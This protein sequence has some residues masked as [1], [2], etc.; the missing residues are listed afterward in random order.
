MIWYYILHA[1][2]NNFRSYI[3]TIQQY[4]FLIGRLL[5]KMTNSIDNAQRTTLDW[6]DPGW[7]TIVNLQRRKPK[8]AFP[9]RS[10]SDNTACL[11][12]ER[13]P[14]PHPLTL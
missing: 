1:K 13:F 10:I 14:Q 12:A 11:C 7:K 5:T 6:L 2:L 9:G 8:F 4:D 3:I